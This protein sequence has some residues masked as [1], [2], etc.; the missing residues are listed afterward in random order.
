[1]AE[2]NLTAKWVIM[3]RNSVHIKRKHLEKVI[4]NLETI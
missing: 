3:N 1:M 2:Q 4:Y